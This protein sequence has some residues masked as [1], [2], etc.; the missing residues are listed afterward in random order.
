MTVQRTI[1]GEE[2]FYIEKLADWFKSDDA[3]D[4]Q[5][6]D[7]FR[8]YDGPPV[9]SL[10]GLNHLVPMPVAVLADGTVHP[11]VVVSPLGEISLNSDY[12]RIVVEIG[13]ASCRER[14]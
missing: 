3:Q 10:S 12:S 6:L 13:R 5:F 2:K 4:S 11:P 9:S 14:V 8:A 1:N 7:S